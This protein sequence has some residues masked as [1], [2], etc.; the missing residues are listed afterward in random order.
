MGTPGAAP[1]A[2]IPGLAPATTPPTFAT[3]IHNDPAKDADQGNY[4]ALLAPFLIDVGNSLT[5][6][7]ILNRINR[8]STAMDPLVF[9]IL[10]GG[11]VQVYLCPQHLDQPLGQPDHPR[12][13][14]FYTFDDDLLGATSYSV[15]VCN[16]IYGLI[17]NSVNVPTLATVNAAIGG[18]PNLQQL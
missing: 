18:N 2:P 16:T 5:P 9:G 17:P 7:E 8:R 13:N 14:R 3:H 1:A 4:A 12:W 11:K 10:V 15:Q 6:E